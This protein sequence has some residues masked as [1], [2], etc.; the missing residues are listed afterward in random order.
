MM[1]FMNGV[2]TNE[3]IKMTGWLTE[4]PQRGVPP[5]LWIKLA[6]IALAGFAGYF[7]LGGHHNPGQ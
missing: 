3:G 2:E 5:D 7:I 6:L 1:L 4:G